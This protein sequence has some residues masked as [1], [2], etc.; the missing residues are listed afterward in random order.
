MIETHGVHVVDV[1]LGPGRQ[2]LRV[3]L[4]AGPDGAGVLTLA[5]GFGG[6]ETGD[7]FLRPDWC[8]LPV[9]LPAAA[10]PALR[11]AL[12]ALEATGVP[13]DPEGAR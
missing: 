10:L 8:G 1:P 5:P 12:G 3:S 9:Q 2:T 11:E 13:G 6:A 7:P 4:M